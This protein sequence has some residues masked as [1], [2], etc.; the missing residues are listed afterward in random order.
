MTSIRTSQFVKR[1][2]R[3]LVVSVVVGAFAFWIT[4]RGLHLN[5]SEIVVW[6]AIFAITGIE[7]LGYTVSRPRKL[8]FTFD[9]SRGYWTYELERRLVNSYE[10]IKTVRVCIATHGDKGFLPSPE[11][12]LG[13]QW[14]G[15]IH[16]IV[17]DEF[18]AWQETV[19]WAVTAEG[20]LFA[21][22]RLSKLLHGGDSQQ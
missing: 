1:A 20:E 3:G 21:S 17:P 4:D 6:C 10:E 5:R 14:T 19:P 22:P 9:R 7:W 18:W 2:V 13:V 12:A 15:K 11:R 8:E 16:C